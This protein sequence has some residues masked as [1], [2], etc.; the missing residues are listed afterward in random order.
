MPGSQIQAPTPP[1]WQVVTAFA[2]IYLIWG[3]TY[4]GIRVAVETIPPLF[5][6]GARAFLAGTALYTLARC[7][8]ADKPLPIHWR[9]AAL[10]GGLL[11]VGGNGLLSWSEQRVPSGISALIIGS[12]PLWMVVLE[13]LLHSGPR[14][15][16]GMVSGL[17]VGFAGLGFLVAPGRLTSSSP[18]DLSGIAVLLLAAFSWA[19]GSLYLRRAPLPSSQILSAAMEMIAGGALLL[20]V[21]GIKGEWT[22]L[23]LTRVTARSWIAWGYLFTFGSLISFTAYVWLLKVSTPARVSTYAYVN[24]VIAVFLG[25][26]F[27]GEQITTHTLLAAA[28]IILA[29]VIIVTR[30]AEAPAEI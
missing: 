10:V 30:A 22:Q 6:A 27:I 12:V 7:R 15:T 21:G 17:I 9:S 1:R 18:S 4:L 8:G 13:W 25:W 23:D 11:L 19:N 20:L 24:P 29:V 16:V 2:A 5:M 26:A 28:G 3:S 14:P